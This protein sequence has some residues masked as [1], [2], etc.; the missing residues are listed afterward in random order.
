MTLPS[1]RALLATS[2]SAALVVV[3]LG[4]LVLRAWPPLLALDRAIEQPV[5]TWALGAPWAV[6]AGDL[7]AAI[8]LFGVSVWVVL[9][10]AVLLLVVRRDW[11]AVLVV[12]VVAIV[13]PLVT[14]AIKEVVHRARPVWD[15]PLALEPSYSYPSG[16]ATAGIAV[17]AVCGL[18]LASLVP[19]R[20]RARAVAA[21]GIALGLSIG[22]SRVVLGVHW[23][24]DV[25]GGW[26]VAVA[27]A[28]LVAGLLV[29]GRP[30]LTAAA[31]GS[32][33]AQ[34]DPAP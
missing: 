14:D 22:V 11:R 18:A 34:G 28:A 25:V 20:R 5:H 16:H 9:A 23:P 4:V 19:D 6:R 15:D 30:L 1:R 31:P 3:L 7:L 10:T 13:A 17:Y 29:P 12:V 8:G 27:V 21:V 32:A 33:D 24:S 26:A 2:A